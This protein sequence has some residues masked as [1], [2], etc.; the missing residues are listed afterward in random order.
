MT[1]KLTTD[2]IERVARAICR[3]DGLNPD[4]VVYWGEPHRV[5]GGFILDQAGWPAWI[6]Y[7]RMAAVAIQAIQ[8]AAP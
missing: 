6:G 8:D 1:H 2:E 5:R 4:V 7:K 3:C